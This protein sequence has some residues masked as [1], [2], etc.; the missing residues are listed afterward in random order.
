M[1]GRPKTMTMR[2][3]GTPNR[4]WFQKVSSWP[5]LV[6]RASSDT[7]MLA[8]DPISVKLPATVLTHP[9]TIHAFTE[10]TPIVAAA[11]AASLGPS[12]ST[13]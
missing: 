4:K 12:K 10:L 11:D 3:D 9:N 5:S 7:M 8:A 2:V 6:R 13:A 1:N